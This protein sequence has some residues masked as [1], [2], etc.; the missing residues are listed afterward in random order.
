MGEEPGLTCR[1]SSQVMQPPGTPFVIQG[2]D[3]SFAIGCDPDADQANSVPGV[4][5]VRT[6]IKLNSLVRRHQR[7]GRPSLAWL[8][9]R[10]EPLGMPGRL[11]RLP[12]MSRTRP[13]RG[14]FSERAIPAPQ[15]QTVN[16]GGTLAQPIHIVAV[17]VGRPVKSL[18]GDQLLSAHH[19]PRTVRAGTRVAHHFRN[20]GMKGEGA[21]APPGTGSCLISATAKRSSF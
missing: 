9:F 10:L 19:R 2:H 15:R 21:N 16:F 4:F 6:T 5:A 1:L 20:P 12:R 14:A 7:S 13:A 11:D 18:P 17:A 3:R 8:S